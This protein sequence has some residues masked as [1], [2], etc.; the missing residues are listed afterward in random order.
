MLEQWK[1]WLSEKLTVPEDVMTNTPRLTMIGQ[2][3]LLVE[4]HHGVRYFSEDRIR[5]QVMDKELLIKGEQF[6]IKKIYPEELLIQGIIEEI[7]YEDGGKDGSISA[8]V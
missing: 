6:T 4:N 5:L 3:H 8:L 2:Y 7:T 1:R